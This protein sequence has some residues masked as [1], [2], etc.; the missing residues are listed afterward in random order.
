MKLTSIILSIGILVTMFS[1]SMEEDMV[2]NIGGHTESLVNETYA[3]LQFSLSS[4]T[5]LNTKT[6]ISGPTTGSTEDVKNGEMAVNKC[7]VF[8]ANGDKI[9]GSR[10]YDIAQNDITLSED[11]SYSLNKSILIKVTNDNQPELTVFAVGMKSDT[12]QKFEKEVFL[13]ATTS[14]EQLKQS[15]INNPL[16]DFIKVGEGT[17][18]PYSED[19]DNGYQVSEKTTN[20]TDQGGTVQPGKAKITLTLKTAAIEIASF[21]IKNSKGEMIFDSQSKET[22]EITKIIKDIQMGTESAGSQTTNTLLD[23]NTEIV[24]KTKSYTSFAKETNSE[25]SGSNPIGYRFYTYQNTKEATMI[26]VAYMNEGK[27]AS[28]TFSVKTSNTAETVLANHLYRIN[29]VITNNVADVKVECY[30]MDWINHDLTGS[31]N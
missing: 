3:E 5:E 25:T 29:V 28:I 12:E 13:T 6:D 2:S 27:E 4:Q 24:S 11:G 31:M 9:I 10:Y 8:V 14:L 16:T 23:N 15:I 18:K 22:A 20:F 1:C 26:T 7:F 30:T 17:I 21:K 19:K